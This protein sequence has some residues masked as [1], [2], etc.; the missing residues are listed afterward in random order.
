[1]LPT[2]VELRSKQMT[3][4]D[5]AR[6]VKERP[7]PLSLQEFLLLTAQECR[8]IYSRREHNYE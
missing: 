5:L 6:E 7:R 3:P 2:L 4:A 8:L 1:M